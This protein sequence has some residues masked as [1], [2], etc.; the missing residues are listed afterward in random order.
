MRQRYRY[1]TNGTVIGSDQIC[2]FRLIAGVKMTH[3]Y[4]GAVALRV[5]IPE[6]LI[7]EKWRCDPYSTTDDKRTL[8]E[9]GYDLM[10]WNIKT[11]KWTIHNE[12]KGVRP[13][14]IPIDVRL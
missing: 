13:C 1:I 14:D 3:P 5:K 11:R 6:D 10:I 9:L 7:L 12:F 4:N 2:D 8:D